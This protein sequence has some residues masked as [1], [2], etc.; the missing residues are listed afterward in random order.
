M[1]RLNGKIVAVYNQKGGVAKTSSTIAFAGILGLLGKN[2]LIVDLDSSGNCTSTFGVG[3]EDE[4]GGLYKMICKDASADET[5]ICSNKAMVDLIPS[6]YGRREACEYL[7]VKKSD[8]NITSY[9]VI[10]VLKRKL[11]EVVEKYDFILIDCPPSADIVSDCV[12]A[13]ATDVIVPVLSDKYSYDGVGLILESI[14]DAQRRYNPELSL[15]GTLA[16]KAKTSR[17]NFKYFYS[18]YITQLPDVAIRQPIHQ[19]AVFEKHLDNNTPV[20]SSFKRS[21]AKADYIKAACEIGFINLNEAEKLLKRF[22]AKPEDEKFE[23]WNEVDEN[24]K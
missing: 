19:D 18:S 17:S 16:T 20:F 1:G 6:G 2:V 10:G 24:G 22:A 12:L 4:P 3:G 13:A 5:I 15:A 21:R 9:E 8:P 14:W 23:Y 11:L 7:V